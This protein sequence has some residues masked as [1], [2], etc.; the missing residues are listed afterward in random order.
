MSLQLADLNEI[1]KIVLEEI[2]IGVNPLAPTKEDEEIELE[3]EANYIDPT[4]KTKAQSRLL[5][6]GWIKPKPNTKSIKFILTPEAEKY[7]QVATQNTELTPEQK[8]LMNEILN[9]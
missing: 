4:D 3:W 1:E 9:Q 2:R 6:K 7:F 5:T 8:A